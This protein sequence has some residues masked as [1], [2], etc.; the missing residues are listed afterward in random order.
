MTLCVVAYIADSGALATAGGTASTAALIVA[1]V[2]AT[3]SP[4]LFWSSASATFGFSAVTVDTADSGTFAMMPPV[5]FENDPVIG[6]CDGKPSCA[7]CWPAPSRLATPVSRG[8]CSVIGSQS[9]RGLEL[10]P[11]ATR[12]FHTD[13]GA[14]CLTYCWR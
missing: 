11:S 13:V 4:A 8:K 9:M 10:A 12:G 1:D 3:H 2:G 6:F 7:T 14:T 5:A